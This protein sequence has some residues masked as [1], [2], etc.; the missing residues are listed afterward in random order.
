ML[1]VEAGSLP[2]RRCLISARF[3]ECALYCGRCF[4]CPRF[5]MH[6]C[7]VTPPDPPWGGVGMGRRSLM[8][9]SGSRR[10][11]PLWWSWMLFGGPWWTRA[12]PGDRRWVEKART[13]VVVLDPSRWSLVRSGPRRS[14]LVARWCRW[15]EDVMDGPLSIMVQRGPRWTKSR[16]VVQDGPCSMDFPTVPRRSELVNLKTEMVSG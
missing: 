10:S 1:K 2:G 14:L 15:S 4:N 9:K 8:T 12:V 11:G 16:R 7:F 5:C 3:A 13:V 6:Q